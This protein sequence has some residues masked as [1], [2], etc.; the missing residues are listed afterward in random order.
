MKELSKKV[1]TAIIIIMIILAG[2]TVVNAATI[3]AN[4]SS[5][6]KLVAGSTIT[7]NINI[8]KPVYGMSTT[9]SYDKDVFE[10]A[11]ITSSVA[12]SADL[13]NNVIVIENGTAMSAGT[14][15]TITLKVKSNISKAEAKV[16]LSGGKATDE[17]VTTQTL[18]NPSITIKSNS[19]STSDSGSEQTQNNNGANA[20]DSKG[21]IT[22]NNQTS[23][24]VTTAK[25]A[26]INNLPK[27]G[28][29]T[30]II[31]ILALGIV[32]GIIFYAKYRNINKYDK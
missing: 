12:T 26:N 30:G 32:L 9:L 4:L 28:L 20:G 3:N 23:N 11:T 5:N 8:D 6:D 7:I 25:K 24:K 15:G 31:V 21:T 18:N 14:I 19:N 27:A 2:A 29:E 17:D 22:N 13:S 10:S 16:S 1:I